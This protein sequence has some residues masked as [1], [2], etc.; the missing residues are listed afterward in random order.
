MLQGPGTIPEHCKITQS[1]AVDI[2]IC[3]NLTIRLK[4]HCNY[5]VIAIC[6]IF[7]RH[8]FTVQ[9]AVPS[10]YL[11]RMMHTL[12]LRIL[13]VHS[14]ISLSL[15]PILDSPIIRACRAW[16]HSSAFEE[17]ITASSSSYSSNTSAST[18]LY[19]SITFLFIIILNNNTLTFYKI[20]I[21]PSFITLS[22]QHTKHRNVE[23]QSF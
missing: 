14:A 20:I 10:L 1:T 16:T 17:N 8:N 3:N 21:R 7:S 22:R 13:R 5:F 19:I 9:G 11:L 6:L 23:Y 2:V 15:R 4:T 12:H 18:F